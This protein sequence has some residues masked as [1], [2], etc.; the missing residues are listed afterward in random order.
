M[1]TGQ[2]KKQ[3]KGLDGFQSSVF[4]GLQWLQVY[5][6]QLLMVCLPLVLILAGGLGWKWYQGYR[7]ELRQSEL[8]K[9]DVLWQVGALMQG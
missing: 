9:I 1:E 5:R 4:S 8:A 2:G 7:T 3:L 6:K